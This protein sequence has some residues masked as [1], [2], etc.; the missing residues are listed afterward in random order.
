MAES[1][2]PL[3]TNDVE[4]DINNPTFSVYIY[5]GQDTDSGWENAQI[6]FGLL[7]RL[8]IYRAAQ[9]N[10]VSKW[11]SD[12]SKR[13]IVFG[14]DPEPRRLLSQAEADDLKAVLNAITSARDAK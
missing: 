11:L 9:G 7:P 10:V 2:P 5:I 3:T 13:G 6:V 12:A 1:I 4:K 8:R 14:F